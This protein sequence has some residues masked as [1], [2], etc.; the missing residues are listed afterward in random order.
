MCAGISIPLNLDKL[1]CIIIA[2]SCMLVYDHADSFTV[3]V[4]VASVVCCSV[5][6]SDRMLRDVVSNDKFLGCFSTILARQ[7]FRPL[8]TYRST[9]YLFMFML[10]ALC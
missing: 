1:H 4:S 9:Y 8:P 3:V 7:A 10:Y 6:F 2:M 5:F